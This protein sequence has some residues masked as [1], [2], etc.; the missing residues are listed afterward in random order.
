MEDCK[1]ETGIEMPRNCN[2]RWPWAEMKIGDS[3]F[4]PANGQEIRKK[5]G[6]ISTCGQSYGKRHGGKRFSTRGTDENG[7]K[8]VRV[9]RVA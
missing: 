6:V 7:E 3:F 9:W 1:V 2:E 4:A 5:Q 8:G